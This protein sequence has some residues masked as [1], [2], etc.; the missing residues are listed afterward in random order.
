[1]AANGKALVFAGVQIAASATTYYTATN[2]QARLDKCTVT[3]ND[4]VA[5]LFSIYLVPSGG[6]AGVTNVTLLNRTINAGE[7]YTCPEI[8]GHWLNNGQFLAAICDAASKCTLRV[9]GIEVT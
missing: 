3:N 8:V 2:V 5:R 6:T 9:S 4:T 7:C 1:M